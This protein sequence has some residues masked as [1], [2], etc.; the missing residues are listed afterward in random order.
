M[1]FWRFHSSFFACVFVH[2]R[3][4]DRLDVVRRQRFARIALTLGMQR[5]GLDPRHPGEQ[6]V[7]RVDGHVLDQRR[8]A[9]PLTMPNAL[10]GSRA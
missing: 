7:F 1:P 6:M 2:E 10:A 4:V 3:V 5:I 9:S 8:L